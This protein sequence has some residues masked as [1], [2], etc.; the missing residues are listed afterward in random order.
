MQTIEY[1][2]ELL[3]P[4]RIDAVMAH[5]GQRNMA[6]VANVLLQ[7][8]HP[9]R[10]GGY[11][12]AVTADIA[13][14]STGFWLQVVDD[15]R[16]HADAARRSLAKSRRAQLDPTQSHRLVDL[17]SHGV[18]VRPAGLDERIPGLSLLATPERLRVVLSDCLGKPLRRL[19]DVE[20]LSHRLGK[21]AVARIRLGAARFIVKCYRDYS[22]RA[23]TT[24]RHMQALRDGGL[25]LAEPVGYSEEWQLLVMQD[26]DGEAPATADD[27]GRAGELLAAL[28]GCAPVT[29]SRHTSAEEIALLERWIDTIQGVGNA[30][31]G[32]LDAALTALRTELTTTDAACFRLSHRDFYEK[33]ILLTTRDA[34]LLD[35]DT[36]ALADPMLDLGNYA[37]HLDLRAC[38]EGGVSAPAVAACEAGYARHLP[39]DTAR[40]SAWRRA[41]ALRL[42]CLYC[43]WPGPGNHTHSML[44][45]A[46]GR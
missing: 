7:R 34:T 9:A 42:A 45:I 15:P 5:W 18:V 2:R 25:R 16:T 22:E 38:Q 27:S 14:R 31:A 17:P 26:V 43:L 20:L 46:H 11:T 32:R 19:P 10:H 35:F 39:V 40:L 13:G 3:L 6:P 8:L 4:G 21:R 23:A 28:H 44:E 37:A 1:L 29:D 41:A 36:L 33:Q 30:C 24:F 12:L